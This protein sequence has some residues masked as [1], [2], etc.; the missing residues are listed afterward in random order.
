MLTSCG[1]IVT[2]TNFYLWRRVQWL[3]SIWTVIRQSGLTG[4]GLRNYITEYSRSKTC[5]SEHRVRR[6]TSS[7]QYNHLNKS[8]EQ[9][10]QHS[11]S[12]R[13][14]TTV[15]QKWKISSTLH[16]CSPLFST[17]L[18]TLPRLLLSQSTPEDR[19]SLLVLLANQGTFLPFMSFAACALLQTTLQMKHLPMSK[20]WFIRLRHAYSDVV[21]LIASIHIMFMLVPLVPWKP[22]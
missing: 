7:V 19:T 15:F 1:K 5:Q 17:L 6:L 9:V 22:S 4:T 12:L 16:S 10:V 13:I 20:L 11:P 18:P 3:S 8:S 2:L 21:L 14:P